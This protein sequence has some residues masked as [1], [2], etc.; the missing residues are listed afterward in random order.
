MVIV[1]F[2]GRR[3]KRR[4]RLTPLIGIQRENNFG[5]LK[6]SKQRKTGGVDAHRQWKVVVMVVEV[7]KSDEMSAK[8][9]R[10]KGKMRF[11][12]GQQC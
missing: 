4:S 12:D 2:E 3:E 11:C 10:E 6:G 7:R 1:V 5:H 9:R 8:Q